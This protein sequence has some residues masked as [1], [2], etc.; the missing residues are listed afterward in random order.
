MVDS[1]LP[2]TNVLIYALKGIEPYS[3]WFKKNIQEKNL[4]ISV[5]VV[6]EFLQGATKEDEIILRLLLDNFGCWSVDRK[7]AEA[8][9][10]YKKSFAMK[11]K[12]AKARKAA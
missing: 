10:S 2:D 6:A 12:K 3:S 9:A 11:T 7:V 1:F 8:G 4:K 5:I